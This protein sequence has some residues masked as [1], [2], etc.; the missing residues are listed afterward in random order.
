[1]YLVFLKTWFWTSTRH[2]VLL[3]RRY[4]RRS[5]T[6]FLNSTTIR[7][8]RNWPIGSPSYVRLQISARSS[9]NL[10]PWIRMVLLHDTPSAFIYIYYVSV[11]SSILLVCL[12]VSV[13]ITNHPSPG[14]HSTDLWS[15][16][17]RSVKDRQVHLCP[18]WSV[19]CPKCVSSLHQCP[20][21]LPARDIPLIQPK[22][23]HIPFSKRFSP[24]YGY[25]SI[26]ILD[27][28]EKTSAGNMIVD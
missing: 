22:K 4:E 25:H 11:L 17:K 1:M 16:F 10:T 3:E 19:H 2:W 18:P 5:V 27:P 23:P 12:C 28:E 13:V 15:R 21:A 20:S 8:R 14:P 7:T 26:P 24:P 9:Q 6:P